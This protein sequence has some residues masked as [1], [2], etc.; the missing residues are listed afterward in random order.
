MPYDNTNGD[1]SQLEVDAFACYF[2]LV[3]RRHSIPWSINDLSKFYDVVAREW[4]A[5]TVVQ[6]VELEMAPILEATQCAV[7]P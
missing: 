7:T 6:G 5:T 4:L 2:S 3:A 1:L